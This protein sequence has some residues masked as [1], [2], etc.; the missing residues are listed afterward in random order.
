MVKKGNNHV[1]KDLTYIIVSTN[2]T[3]CWIYI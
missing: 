2:E 3:L 1:K